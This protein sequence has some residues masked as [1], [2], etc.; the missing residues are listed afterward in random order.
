MF[1]I[2]SFFFLFSLL[3]CPKHCLRMLFHSILFYFTSHLFLCSTIDTQLSRNVGDGT[4][5]GDD[6]AAEEGAERRGTRASA[7]GQSH[8]NSEES[9]E[10]NG[11]A[12]GG[13]R[14]VSQVDKRGVKT[15]VRQTQDGDDDDD[16]VMQVDEEEVGGGGGLAPSIHTIHPPKLTPTHRC[17]MTR[18]QT[19]RPS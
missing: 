12:D 4:Q 19:H 6:E 15:E 8:G 13:K 9:S 10:A 17:H 3:K 5:V 2:S 1:V 16:D 14:G 7:R 18:Q 11:D